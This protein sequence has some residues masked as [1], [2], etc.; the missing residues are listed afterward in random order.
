MRCRI[1][2]VPARPGT[3]FPRNPTR[4]N[5]PANNTNST[6]F[7][8]I[9]ASDTI[10]SPFTKRR[11]LR[12]FTGTGLGPPNVK[13][14]F[15]AIHSITGKT[16]PMRR[17]MLVTRFRWQQLSAYAGECGPG[18]PNPRE[19]GRGVQDP[20]PTARP[21]GAEKSHPPEYLGTA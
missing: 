11:Q 1:S 6:R 9:P 18:R 16:T 15:D 13:V 4:A 7:T 20:L 3:A 5:S 8:A 17:S 2:S 12:G 14:P 10:T 21:G 19:G